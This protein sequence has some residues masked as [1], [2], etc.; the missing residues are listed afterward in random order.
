MAAIADLY[1]NLEMVIEHVNDVARP[2][3]IS[4]GEDT[5][6]QELMKLMHENLAVAYRLS[7]R[8]DPQPVKGVPPRGDPSCYFRLSNAGMEVFKRDFGPVEE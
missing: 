6:W 3:G 7:P 8:S 5:V 2:R 4:L 1:E